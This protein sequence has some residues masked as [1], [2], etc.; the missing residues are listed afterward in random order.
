[1]GTGRSLWTRR[2]TRSYAPGD[3]YFQYGTTTTYGAVTAKQPLHGALSSSLLSTTVS[4]LAAGTTYHFRLVVEN[5]AGASY[6]ADQSFT[7]S[8]AAV[9]PPTEH[10][11]AAVPQITAFSQT[12]RTWRE[13]RAL[14][15]LASG[16]RL[17]VG[18]VF[19]L[20]LNEAATLHLVFSEQLPGRHVGHRCVAPTRADRHH[21]ACKRL[22][23]RGILTLSGHAGADTIRFDGRLS[24]TRKLPTGNYSVAITATNLAGRRSA[25]RR[26]SFTIV[27]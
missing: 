5:A 22:L 15:Q 23:N 3:V 25:T 16:H 1:M 27:R 7:T 12:R 26:L 21:H 17:P 10:V 6:G 2:A 14:A 9:I 18:T 13:G 11:A 4:G 19:K 20:A 24:R 8:P